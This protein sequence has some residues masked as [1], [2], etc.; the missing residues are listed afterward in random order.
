MV[1]RSPPCPAVVHVYRCRR[2]GWDLG[3][4]WLSPKDGQALCCGPWC[5][6]IPQPQETALPLSSPPPRASIVPPQLDPFS[7]AYRQNEQTAR[8]KDGQW[9]QECF[10]ALEVKVLRRSKNG[11]FGYKTNL[12]EKVFPWPHKAVSSDPKQHPKLTKCSKMW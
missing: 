9:V 11:G 7:I 8:M 6:C 1:S 3:T 2:D 5:K 12:K 10:V 4:D